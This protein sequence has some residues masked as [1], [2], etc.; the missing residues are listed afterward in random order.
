MSELFRV[1]TYLYK[2]I[3]SLDGKPYCMR[4]IKNYRINK[5]QEISCIDSWTKITHCGIVSVREA[6]TTK[7]F[8]DICKEKISASFGFYIRLVS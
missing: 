8:G 1:Q 7:A 2:T 5:E 3:N 4:R 6:F